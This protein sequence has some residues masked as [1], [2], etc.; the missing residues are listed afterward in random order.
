MV[1]YLRALSTPQAGVT[2]NLLRKYFLARLWMTNTA[3][4][5]I[6]RESDSLGDAHKPTG[7]VAPVEMVRF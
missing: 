4:M 3:S 1:S 5:M 2:S 7:Q 6:E